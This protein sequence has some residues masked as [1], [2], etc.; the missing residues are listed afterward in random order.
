MSPLWL[1]IG[2]VL[3]CKVQVK[4]YQVSFLYGIRRNPDTR[5]SLSY[6]SLNLLFAALFA[7]SVHTFYTYGSLRLRTL[8]AHAP[9]RNH[10]STDGYY[11]LLT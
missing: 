3:P 7:T 6:L 5:S 10:V 8:C 2:P 4:K 1:C 11:M 9:R